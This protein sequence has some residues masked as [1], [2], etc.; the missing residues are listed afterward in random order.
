M[1]TIVVK[2]I[3]DGRI[4]TFS[5]VLTILF[6]WILIGFNANVADSNYYQ[7]L[8]NRAAAGAT[9][10]AVE[11][12]FWGLIKL[13]VKLGISYELFL[14]IYSAVGLLLIASTVL[15][16]TD[17]PSNVFFAYFCYPLLLDVAQIRHFMAIA[18]FIFAVRYLEKF[19]VK[20]SIKYCLLIILAASQ[21]IIALAFFIFLLVYLTDQRM[22]K[23]I[24][25]IL[26]ICMFFGYRLLNKTA[27]FNM[28]L[29]L[30]N[31]T[32]DYNSSTPLTQFL[33]YGSFFLILLAMCVF[34]N[35][36]SNRFFYNRV[37]SE[38]VKKIT[39]FYDDT[40]LFKLCMYSAVFIPTILLDFQYTRLFRGC[41]ILVY[42]YITNNLKYLKKDIR[43]IMNTVF[44]LM[45]I[46]VGIKLF[47]P[48]SGYYELLTKPIFND[49][50]FFDLIF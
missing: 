12:G 21:Q 39:T 35:K 44:F 5:F 23:R 22:A 26:T 11:S 33:L 41:L 13:S 50:R 7:N 28:I 15:K 48:S 8:F 20:N 25:I 27:L 43:I 14:K 42:I 9:N 31:K 49:N 46:M 2:R 16:Y 30:R 40:F 10:H 6:I 18:L 45:M 1:P 3:K 4:I 47:G 38:G 17:H 32:I 29:S 19:S 37:L 34:L 36:R 24:A